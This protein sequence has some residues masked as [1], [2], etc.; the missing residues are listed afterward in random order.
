MPRSKAAALNAIQVGDVVASVDGYV[1]SSSD[2]VEDAVTLIDEPWGSFSVAKLLLLRE[3][4]HTAVMRIHASIQR[5][6]YDDVG[7]DDDRRLHAMVQSGEPALEEDLTIKS[8]P[9]SF[10]FGHT[11]TRYRSF[12][13]LGSFDTQISRRQPSPRGER[14]GTVIFREVRN[15]EDEEMLPGESDI[16]LF[17]KQLS[18]GDSKLFAIVRAMVPGGAAHACQRI[19]I[20]DALLSV[21]GRSVDTFS[22]VDDVANALMGPEYSHVVLKLHRALTNSHY[23]V[24]LVRKA[25]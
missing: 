24:T 5:N 12:Y 18:L 22:S 11:T 14:R 17:L 1:L 20:G 7:W 4:P 3:I 9:R 8:S 6:W 19:M 13:S 15:F 23:T 25:Q 10:D 21:D 16:G 2:S